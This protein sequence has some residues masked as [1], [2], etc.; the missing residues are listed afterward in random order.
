LSLV[1]A[2]NSDPLPIDLTIQLYDTLN[3]A[4]TLSIPESEAV[5]LSVHVRYREQINNTLVQGT[6]LYNHAV[7]IQSGEANQTEV[8]PTHLA[9][10]RDAASAATST[11]QGLIRELEEFLASAL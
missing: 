4:P 8:S 1:Q 9:L 2:L 10:A 11:L 3:A 7:A 6:D 5:L